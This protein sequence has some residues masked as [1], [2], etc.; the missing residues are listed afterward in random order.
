MFATTRGPRLAPPPRPAGR[1]REGWYARSPT[2]F[3]KRPCPSFASARPPSKPD[4]LEARSCARRVAQGCDPRAEGCS[5]GRESGHLVFFS[6]LLVR[7]AF[8]IRQVLPLAARQAVGFRDLLVFCLR[9]VLAIR[10]HC[11]LSDCFL[12]SKRGQGPIHAVICEKQFCID[13]LS[14]ILCR[15]FTQT[16]RVGLS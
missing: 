4:R 3:R 8:R 11:K 1:A 15:G 10:E 6:T 5:T 14:A 7:P 12:V 13:T 2:W 9:V 16:F